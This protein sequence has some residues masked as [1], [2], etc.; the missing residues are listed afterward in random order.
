MISLENGKYEFDVVNGAVMLTVRDAE[1]R[2]VGQD[3]YKPLMA[4]IGLAEDAAAT[5]KRVW[6]HY[7]TVRGEAT[8]Y[9]EKAL[10]TPRHCPDDYEYYTEKA[11]MFNRIAQDLRTALDGEN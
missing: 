9:T 1:P 5:Q 6:D 8:Y 7:R 3:F 2:E 11:R 4:L 10:D